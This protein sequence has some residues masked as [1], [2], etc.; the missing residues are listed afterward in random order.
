MERAN[1]P[2]T[3]PVDLTSEE[4]RERALR[5][6]RRALGRLETVVAMALAVDVVF[7][8]QNTLRSI[9]LLDL[10]VPTGFEAFGVS[11]NFHYGDGVDAGLTL[12]AICFV[13]IGVVN[14]VVGWVAWRRG[15]PALRRAAETSEGARRTTLMGALDD[16]RWAI[17][18]IVGFIG[19]AVA[20]GIIVGLLDAALFLTGNPLI[21]SDAVNFVVNVAMCSVVIAGYF[22]GT[23]HLLRA[24]APGAPVRLVDRFSSDQDWVLVGAIVGLGATLSAVSWQFQVVSVFSLSLILVGVHGFKTGYTALLPAA[25]AGPALAGVLPRAGPA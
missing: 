13:I 4:H 2:G 15:M 1:A 9:G 20:I 18:S 10:G 5:G 24:A 22:F 11:W 19:V 7:L 16:Q 8:L 21:A 23:R 3:P 17:V 6:F 12:L 25:P 14:A